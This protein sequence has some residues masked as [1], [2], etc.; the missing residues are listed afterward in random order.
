M[1]AA[2][3]TLVLQTTRDLTLVANDKRAKLRANRVQEEEN[4]CADLTSWRL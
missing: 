1:V 2:G 4:E 3:A